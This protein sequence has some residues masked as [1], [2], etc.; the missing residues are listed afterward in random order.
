MKNNC[1]IKCLIFVGVLMALAACTKE[2]NT[3]TEYIGTVVE[4]TMMS[5]LP[6]VKVSVT[7]GSRVLVSTVTDEE[8]AFSLLVNFA[9]VV[10]G[11]SLLLDGSPELPFSKKYAL[12]GV[13]AEQYDYRT[14]V[15]YNKSNT[16]VETSEVTSITANSAVCGGVITCGGDVQIVERGVCWSKSQYP[17]IESVHTSDGQGG[18]HFTS[19]LSNLEEKK[20]FY[21]RAYA[22]TKKGEVIYGEQKSFTTLAFITTNPVTFIT[23]NTAVCGGVVSAE[24]DNVVKERGV[25]WAIHEEPK[26]NDSYTS[27]GQGNGEFVSNITGLEEQ[28]TYYIRAFAKTESTIKYGDQKLFSTP[29][30]LPTFQYA[31]TIYY[32]H[33]DAGT[34]TW[35]SAMDYCDNLTFADYSD[36]FLPDQDELNAM[37]V[38]RNTIGGFVTTDNTCYWSSTE[39]GWSY[40]YSAYC[41]CYQDFEGGAQGVK[42]EREYLRVRPVR[43]DGSGGGGITPTAPTVITNTPTGVTTNSAICG[44]NVT[45]DGGADVIQRG[46]CYSTS[47]NP[48]TSSHVVT[49][50]VGMGTFSCTLTGLSANKIYYV[51]AYAINSVGTAYGEQMSFTTESGGGTTPVSPTVTT[52]TPS[53]VTLSSALCGGNVTS[54]GGA[55][56]IQRGVCYSTSQNPTT[57][58]QIVTSGIGT[59]SFTCNLTGLSENTTYYVRAYAIN[60]VGTAYGEQKNFTTTNGGNN[61]TTPTVTTSTP[62]DIYTYSAACGGNVTSDGGASVI[63]RGICYS[64]SQ[65]PT[66]N[67]WIATSGEGTGSFTCYMTGLNQNTTYYVRAFATNSEGTSYGNQVSFTTNSEPNNAFL[68]YDDGNGIDALGFEEGGT[69]YWADM[70][71][72]SM[73]SSYGGTSVT[74]VEAY[75]NMAGVYTLRLYSG[76]T[77]SPGTLIYQQNFN[78]NYS[79]LVWATMT[80]ANPVL[81][82]TSQNLWVVI[83]VTHS[84][85]EYPAGCCQNSGDPNG[86]WV[87]D[88][89]DWEDIEDYTWGMHTYVTNSVKGDV[90]IEIKQLPSNNSKREKSPI[91]SRLKKRKN[92]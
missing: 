88:G 18:G 87:S 70:F 4:G 85:G 58:S 10:E 37:Y 30:L 45:A 86:R 74:K 53:S 36:W 71:P 29:A 55:N 50:G 6:N 40:N 73:L 21:V 56:V 34:M 43:K 82:N 84:A 1:L 2:K 8:G 91:I 3:I 12:K 75:L 80:L 47:Q 23:A 28:T 14:L 54:D 64:T 15:L 79:S 89:V 60:S 63:Q 5:P 9:K 39:S 26:I 31:G 90:P 25:C 59:G 41:A 83:S 46:V 62:F 44:G 42:P 19:Y 48:N 11:D 13:N 17:T 51:R 24:N 92:N 57:S 77:T 38:N 20:D 72:S 52:S 7:N 65:N 49:S 32:V 22:K 76:G 81:L 66:I 69:L 33:P 16:E 78:H 68:Q 67:S 35:Q 61:A 27:N